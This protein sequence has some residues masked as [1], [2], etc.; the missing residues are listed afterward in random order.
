ME[1]PAT[2]RARAFSLVEVIVV[3][4]IMGVLAAVTIPRITG[5]A[6]RR[7]RA[8]AESLADLLATAARRES[9]TSQQSIVGYRKDLHAISLSVLVATEGESSSAMW[10]EDRLAP[11]VNLGEAVIQAVEAD[12]GAMDPMEWSFDFLPGVRR[13]GLAIVLSDP[14]NR[15]RWRVEL[16]SGAAHAVVSQAEF[17]GLLDQSIDLDAAGAGSAAW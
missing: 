5:M 15:E 17:S 2:S 13:P 6:G 7:V 9:L 3:I 8:T 12:G 11:S 4:V 16:P 10:V 14:A 1:R